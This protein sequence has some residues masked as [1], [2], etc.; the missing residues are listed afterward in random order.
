M[1]FV[2]PTTSRRTLSRGILFAGCVA[3]AVVGTCG[4]PAF[5]QANWTGGTS[6][7]YFDGANWSGGT[8]P[9]SGAT[10]NILTPATYMPSYTGDNTGN[11]TGEFN[12]QPGATFTMTSGTFQTGGM[13]IPSNNASG[14][15]TFNMVSG[16][17]RVAAGPSFNAGPR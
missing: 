8:V 17:V 5:A 7:D 6:T 9:A 12:V 11:Q 15:A 1:R 16:S 4:R 13:N 14:I 3:A 10:V 2:P